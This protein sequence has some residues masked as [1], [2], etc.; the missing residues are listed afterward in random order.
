MFGLWMYC[1]QTGCGLLVSEI[2][3]DEERKR[4]SRALLQALS[5]TEGKQRSTTEYSDL[6]EKHGFIPK[7][8]K[9]IDNLLDAM[10]FVKED[11]NDKRTL[12]GCSSASIETAELEW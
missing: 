5:M 4:P 1:Y 9:H 3:L 11:P 2:F 7:H 12:L 6:L 10:L 8:I